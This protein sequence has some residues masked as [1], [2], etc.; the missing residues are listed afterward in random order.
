MRPNWRSS[1]VATDDAIVSG[2]APGKRACT[3]DGREIH[4]R[5]RRNRQ[6][7]KRDHAGQRE[8]EVSSV[9]ATGRDER[10]GDFMIACAARLVSAASTGPRRRIACASR[11]K[12]R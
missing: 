5:Q 10:R 6:Q 2:L 11:S 7:L 3:R 9:V 1:G 4:L 8:R 12:Q